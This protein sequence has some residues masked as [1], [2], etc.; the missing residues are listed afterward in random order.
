M[1]MNQVEIYEGEAGQ[2]VIRQEAEQGENDDTVVI[3]RDQA[4]AVADAIVD[5]AAAMAVEASRNGG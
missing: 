5:I 2:I 4:E 1:R 3:T